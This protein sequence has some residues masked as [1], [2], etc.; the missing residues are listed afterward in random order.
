MSIY[1]EFENRVGR[2]PTP[3][4]RETLRKLE[5]H[6]ILFIDETYK[7]F[8]SREEM[9][10]AFGAFLCK[11]SGIYRVPDYHIQGE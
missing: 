10:R 11:H 4:E 1:D 5:N 8:G 9:T 2:P 6:E 3:E 7:L